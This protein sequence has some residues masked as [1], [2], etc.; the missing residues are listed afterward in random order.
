MSFFVIIQPI[1]IISF[2]I[3]IG[4]FISKTYTFNEDTRKLFI[5]LI[6]NTGMPAIILSSIFKVEID[7]A[8]FRKILLVLVISIAIN[9]IGIF[10][11]LMVASLLHD[12]NRIES[13]ILSGL[14]NAGFIGIPLCAVLFGPEGALFAAIFDAG[15]D[16]T[17]W[18]V[19]V[20]L[21]NSDERFSFKSLKEI[22]NIPF[23]AIIVGLVAAYIG[24][25]PPFA[26]NETIDYLAAFVVPLAMFYI[27]GLL[28]TMRRT[29]VQRTQEIIW[30][31]LVVKLIVLPFIAV[32]IIKLFSV[33]G[34]LAHIILIQAMMPSI[35]VASIIFAKYRRDSEYG[36]IVTI[37][38]TVL[39]LPLIPIMY[40]VIT[41]I[42]T[43]A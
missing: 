39:S 23:V 29:E 13:A 6:V 2:L 25:R 32:F 35:T 10:L 42:F 37:T 9:L 26:I 4:F 15:V 8:M 14:G 43:I 17:I 5:T 19:G 7:D 18:T 40:F 41:A 38:S 30:L 16:L 1:L 27:G 20:T 33:T 3:L 12:R 31:P 34:V 24:Y 22:V 21:L 36:A 28:S 11:G